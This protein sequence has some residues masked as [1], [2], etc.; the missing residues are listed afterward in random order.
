MNII[1]MILGVPGTST[2]IVIPRHSSYKC[3]TEDMS[4]SIFHYWRVC[5]V[6]FR[7]INLKVGSILDCSE[8][9]GIKHF[10]CGYSVLELPTAGWSCRC[11]QIYLKLYNPRGKKNFLIFQMW[12][13]R[14]GE[15]KWIRFFKIHFQ[16]EISRN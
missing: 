14:F 15:S 11:V 7:S 6:V 8:Q 16:K 5:L 2:R 9:L 13:P 3:I 1:Y 10:A 12:K 4:S